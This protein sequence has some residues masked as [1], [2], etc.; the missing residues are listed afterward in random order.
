MHHELFVSLQTH[1]Y[2]QG[3]AF[4]GVGDL[5]EFPAE[6]RHGYPYGIALGVTLDPAI[7]AQLRTGPTKA[8]EAEY[9]RLNALL[10][11]LAESGAEF[12]RQQGFEA[13]AAPPTAQV[14]QSSLST[15]FPH[16]TVATRA[17]LGW[18][19]KCDL[20]VTKEFGSAIRLTKIFTNAELPVGTPINETLCGNCQ[21][22]VDACPA[23]APTGRNWHAGMARE[24]MYDVHACYRQTEL[25]ME[26]RGINNHICGICIAVC[27][28]TQQYLKRYGL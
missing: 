23:H 5:R 14:N 16:K 27:P 26:E 3:A 24:E 12:L 7:V 17:G 11:V 4:V 6:A 25:W 28:Y 13:L 8:Y 1:L 20:F 18:I 22:C 2:S 19:G 9:N 15:N 21:V 10:K